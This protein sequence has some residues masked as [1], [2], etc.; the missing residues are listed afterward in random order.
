MQK[1]EALLLELH[2]SVDQARG[3]KETARIDLDMAVIAKVQ[4]EE[5][6]KYTRA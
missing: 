2:K 4:A 5:A 1:M 6:L 3:E